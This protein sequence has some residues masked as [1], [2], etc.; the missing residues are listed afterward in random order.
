LPVTPTPFYGG[1]IDYD[2]LLKLLDHLFPELDGYTL[3]GSTG[4]SAS[5]SLDERLELMTFAA[6]NTP[7]GK[8]IVV[9]L[10]HTSV[11]EMSRLAR[12]AEELGIAAGLVPCPYYFPNSFPMVLEFFQA[13]DRSFDL[14]YV[15]YDNP[16]YTKTWLR[17]EEILTLCDAC[18]HLRAVKMTDH[19]L[20]KIT[21]LKNRDVTVFS[22]DDVV[23]FRSLLLGVDGSMI[24][25]P[26]VFPAPFQRVVRLIG[27]GD[28]RTALRLFS[29]QILPFIHLFGIG[30]EV[31]TT[32]ALFKHLGIFHSGEVRPPLL[33][34]T[35]ER[36]KE[37]LL[38]YEVCQTP[39]SVRQAV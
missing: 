31:S 36:L 29:D 21:A 12:R 13:L 32:K 6:Q 24:I 22:G 2:S 19:N 15:L 7:P 4:E 37:I 9:G 34:S 30:D 23:A 38:A 28:T 14:G 8:T 16:L 1:K 3:C 39:G 25:A 10:T 26:A 17:V 33:P 27:Q 20:D 18:K 35:P 5:L 11:N